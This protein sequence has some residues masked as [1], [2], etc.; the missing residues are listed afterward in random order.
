[1]RISVIIPAKNA[2]TTLPLCLEALHH[3]SSFRF[4]EDFEIIVVDDGSTDATSQRAQECGARVVSQPNAGPASARNTGARSALGEII[5]FTDADCIP[6]PEWLKEITHPFGNEEVM[7]VKGVYR[8]REKV[9]IARFVQLEYESKYERMLHQQQIDFIDTYSAAYR[10]NIFLENEGFDEIFP[11]PSVED[12]EFSFRL[13]RKGYKLV[14]A[15]KAIVYH[16]H[17]LTLRE[18]IERKAGIGYWKAVMINWLPEKTFSDSHTPPS[19]RLQIALLAALLLSLA[20][21]IFWQ[22]AL[23]AAAFLFLL[24]LIT[25][26]PFL[27]FT[28][29]RDA[30]LLSV[31]LPLLFVR[32]LSTGAGIAWGMLFSGKFRPHRKGLNMTER[33]F[34]R[35]LD[36]LGAVVGLVLTAPLMLIAAIAIKLDSPGPII[37]TQMRAGENGKPFH[38]HKLRTMFNGAEHHLD[39]VMKNNPLRGPVFKIPNDARITRLGR[40]LRRWSLDEM[41]QFWDVLTGNMSL[42]GPRP[43]ELWVVAQYN[44][45]QRQRLLVKPGITGPMQVSG[46]GRLDMDA[47]LQL[48]MHYVDHYSFGLDL[49]IIFQ[50]FHAIFNGDGAY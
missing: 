17:D 36:L 33:I 49:Q 32:A 30:Q 10:R 38:C 34:K 6:S 37:F 16:H 2:Q 31:V 14:F 50:T 12:Q 39:Q 22:P 11:V 1:M 9:W 40:F 18:Y 23:W 4:G 29:Q 42:V 15:S 27:K 19:Q 8:T 5:A 44:D 26:I 41:P 43:E 25:A 48:E 13:A 21:A 7:G 47:R 3:Q 45:E 46:R 24:F 28:V 20:G 35:L